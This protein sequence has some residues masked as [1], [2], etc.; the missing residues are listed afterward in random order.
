M[1]WAFPCAWGGRSPV[2]GVGVPPLGWGGCTP[3]GVGWVYPL[4]G[5]VGVPPLGWGG[6]TPSGVGWAYPLWGGVGVPPLGWGGRAPSGVGWA[7]PLWGGV[8]VPPLGWV[9][10]LWGGVGVPPLGWGV[11]IAPVCPPVGVP[12]WCM[13]Y[14]PCGWGCLSGGL[15]GP[16]WGGVVVVA[17]LPYRYPYIL[18]GG[19]PGAT[20]PIQ[21]DPSRWGDS[22]ATMGVSPGGGT[23]SPSPPPWGVLPLPPLPGVGG[24]P[25]SGVPGLNRSGSVVVVVD[26]DDAGS[27]F[28]VAVEVNDDVVVEANLIGAGD[29]VLAAPRSAAVLSLRGQDLNQFAVRTVNV[30]LL[31]LDLRRSDLAADDVSDERLGEV[32]RKALSSRESHVNEH[33]VLPLRVFVEVQR[34]C[35]KA[36]RERETAENGH[37]EQVTVVTADRLSN[38]G[39]RPKVRRTGD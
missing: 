4:W 6:R 29:A 19:G 16:L 34:S 1:G 26:V 23:P 38:V 14:P 20:P 35:L 28:A 36:L 18:L 30:D 22:V 7:C 33:R 8:G 32:P 9:Y 21:G 24:P 3:S 31:A 25:P 37:L 17:G 27:N 2:R 13:G 5:G 10:P 39:E 11:H 12:P 15:C